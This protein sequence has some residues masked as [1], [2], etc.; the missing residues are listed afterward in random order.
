MRMRS[1]SEKDLPEIEKLDVR[2]TSP[3]SRYL[4]RERIRTYPELSYG[5]FDNEK[6]VGFVLGKEL[7]NNDI[8]LSRVVVDRKHEGKGYAKQLMN[9]VVDTHKK[10][11][12]SDVT[13]SNIRSIHLHKR[14]GFTPLEGDFR[15]SDGERKIMFLRDRR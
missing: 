15:Y 14:C 2:F 3:W 5:L 6:L 7:P 10:R 13:E 1:L 9:K 8:Y 12:T 11:I 4:Y